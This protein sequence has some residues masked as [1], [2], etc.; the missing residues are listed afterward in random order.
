MNIP[1]DALIQK[2]LSTLSADDRLIFESTYGKRA[3]ST[4]VAYLLWLL[5]GWHYAY[6]GKWGVQVLYWVTL[7]GFGIWALIDLFRVPGLIETYNREV[8][9]QSLQDVKVLTA[10]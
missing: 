4:G 7:A 10:Q 3:K 8:A 1:R 6:V 9:I 5:L 2:S